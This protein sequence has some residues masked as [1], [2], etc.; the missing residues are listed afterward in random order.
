[1]RKGVAQADSDQEGKNE[2]KGKESRV[3]SLTRGRGTKVGGKNGNSPKGRLLKGGKTELRGCGER[4]G[5]KGIIAMGSIRGAS[6]R[7]T[8]FLW[9]PVTARNKEI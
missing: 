7:K 9:E 5:I 4:N 1:M 8:D 6:L 2:K 3:G